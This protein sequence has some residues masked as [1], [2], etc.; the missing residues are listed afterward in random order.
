MVRALIPF[1]LNVPQS[2]ARIGG[3]SLDAMKFFLKQQ[4][5]ALEDN[6]GL[7]KAG[8]RE[9][10]RE[11]EQH[12]PHHCIRIL[13]YYVVV[14]LLR[15]CR[16]AACLYVLGSLAETLVHCSLTAGLGET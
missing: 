7:E 9:K 12:S 8:E 15:S 14:E 1:G 10:E 3:L 16:L 4:Q 6:Q 11:R 5:K 13:S 2:G